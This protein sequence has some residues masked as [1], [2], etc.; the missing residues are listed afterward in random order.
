MN[1]P[2]PDMS[3]LQQ[4]TQ[5]TAAL[6]AGAASAADPAARAEEMR[7]IR[8]E[9]AA[10]VGEA[11]DDDGYVTATWTAEKGFAGLTLDP[12][13]MR[14]PS[15]DLAA[16]IVRV[17]GLAR[18]DFEAKRREAAAAFGPLPDVDLDE[19]Q[20]NIDEVRESFS[21]SLGDVQGMMEQF[22]R[23]MGDLGR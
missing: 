12:R 17:S 6:Q 18:E 3:A 14:M 20:A 8:D 1:F 5:M 10:V 11:S 22:R 19:A 15:V 23:Q 4:L 2:R 13:A 21:R 16:E 9:V 7:R